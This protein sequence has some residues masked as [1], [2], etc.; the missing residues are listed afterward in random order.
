[1]QQTVPLFIEGKNTEEEMKKKNNTQHKL[2]PLT[3]SNISLNSIINLAI[4]FSVFAH[5][6]FL[7]FAVLLL[8]CFFF[9]L[10]CIFILYY[11]FSCGGHNLTHL[12][13]N[14]QMARIYAFDYI[15]IAFADRPTI[16]LHTAN[17]HNRNV[18]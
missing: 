9:F 11:F 10:S 14:I 16:H 18:A 3:A 7:F 1:M 15:S 13:T 17:T 8:F 4:V 12:H 5:F 6:V 2:V